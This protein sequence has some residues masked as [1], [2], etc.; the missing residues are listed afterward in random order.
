MK[1]LKGL[2]LCHSLNIRDKFQFKGISKMKFQVS[3]LMRVQVHFISKRNKM[4]G[5]LRDYQLIQ[6][7]SD[8]CPI[9]VLGFKHQ[10]NRYPD[11]SNH[12]L[13]IK[14]FDAFVL[15]DSSGEE[16]NLPSVPGR[17]TRYE[18]NVLIN[19]PW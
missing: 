6:Q 9:H 10:V 14:R 5:N 7:L 16:I 2:L 11:S 1:L 12:N 4:F 17:N 19:F 15:K 13:K 3:N 8:L 18:E